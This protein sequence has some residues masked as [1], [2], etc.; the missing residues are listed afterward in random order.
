MKGTDMN[1]SDINRSG[2]RQFVIGKKTIDVFPAADPGRPIVYLNA[3]PGEGEEVLNALKA[4]DCPD[5]TLAAV[6][7]LDWNRDLSPWEAP[8]VFKGDSPFEGGADGYLRLLTGSI[9]PKCEE[10]I[11]IDPSWRGIAGYSMAGLFAVYAMY[12]TDVFSRIAS[13]SGSL[14]FPGLSEF[15]STHE[16]AVS[17]DRLYLSLGDKEH[18]TRNPHMKTVRTC[19]EELAAYCRSRNIPTEFRLNPG[20]HFTDPV[21]R[22]ALGIRWI[23]SSKSQRIT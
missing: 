9:I 4:T 11:Q 23:L 7:D 8:S 22:T 2:H 1:R 5:F 14:W 15:A 6:S 10:K 16:P 17:P 13:M 19:T 18:K 3:F 20:N 21:G 12:R